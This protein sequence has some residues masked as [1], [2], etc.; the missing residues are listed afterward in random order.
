VKGFRL[1]FGLMQRTKCAC[2]SS[3]VLTNECIELRNWAPTEM[4]CSCFGLF[5]LA[6]ARASLRRAAAVPTLAVG[7]N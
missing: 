5:P 6:G 3:S 2:V 4:K 1:S 7:L